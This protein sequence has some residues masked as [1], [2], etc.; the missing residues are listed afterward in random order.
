MCVYIKIYRYRFRSY[1][2]GLSIQGLKL[3]V[4]WGHAGGVE[5]TFTYL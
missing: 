5:F 4:L 1:G 2:L 3:G